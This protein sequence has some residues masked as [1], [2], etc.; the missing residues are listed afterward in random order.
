[1][2]D[3]LGIVLTVTLVATA[4]LPIPTLPALP[5]EGF[6]GTVQGV[7][8]PI[9]AQEVAVMEIITLPV[10]SSSNNSAIPVHRLAIPVVMRTMRR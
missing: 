3:A 7:I 5:L 1:M 2:E 10:P 4:H 8:R 9:L 6:L